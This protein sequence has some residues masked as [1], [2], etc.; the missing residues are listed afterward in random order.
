MQPCETMSCRD[1]NVGELKPI[2]YI[3]QKLYSLIS[4]DSLNWPRSVHFNHGNWQGL[5]KNV[6]RG[7]PMKTSSFPLPR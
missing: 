5:P 1:Q 2:M 7:L 6:G 4:F 3:S